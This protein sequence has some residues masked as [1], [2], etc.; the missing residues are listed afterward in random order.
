MDTAYRFENVIPKK[1]GFLTILVLAAG[2]SV[3][4]AQAGTEEAVAGIVLGALLISA[5]QASQ[6]DAHD[7]RREYYSEVHYRERHSSYGGHY[8]DQRRHVGATHQPSQR[9]H[10]HHRQERYEHHAYHQNGGHYNS[11]RKHEKHHKYCDHRRDS[12]RERHY[13]KDRYSD[14]YHRSF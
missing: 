2:L 9:G 11:G 14:N 3:K 8:V 13:K 1:R 12:H 4:P 10:K 6:A 7:S 5:A